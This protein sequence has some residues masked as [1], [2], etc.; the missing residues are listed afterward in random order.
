M[1]KP[2]IGSVRIAGSAST[3]QWS[4]LQRKSAD[5]VKARAS[6]ESSMANSSPSSSPLIP[7]LVTTDLPL[8]LL[9]AD[10][11]LHDGITWDIDTP[12]D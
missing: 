10:E 1:C 3:S 9:L 12:E 2:R 8:E 6:G 5:A 11:D 7:P 4:N